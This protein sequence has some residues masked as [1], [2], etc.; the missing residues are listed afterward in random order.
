MTLPIPLKKS[1]VRARASNM[2]G[3]EKHACHWPNCQKI[4]PPSM[5]G[6]K[7]HWFILPKEL[8]DLIWETYTPGQEINGD[9]VKMEYLEASYRV[10]NWITE[11]TEKLI[12]QKELPL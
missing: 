9:L 3:K 1:W 12:A 8:R 11:Y 4:V 5:W 10:Q 2:A 7:Q 6:C